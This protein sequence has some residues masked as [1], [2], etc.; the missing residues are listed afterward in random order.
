LSAPAQGSWAAAGNPCQPEASYYIL[1]RSALT[2]LTS[3]RVTRLGE[4]SPRGWFFTLNRFLKKFRSSP[5]FYYPFHRKSYFL[6][7]QKY[8]LGN[9]LVIFLRNRLEP[10]L[11]YLNL[12][13]F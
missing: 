1:G 4:F 5:T 6:I 13:V 11:R 8:V 7:W 10:I 9:I 3:S 12:H 2:S